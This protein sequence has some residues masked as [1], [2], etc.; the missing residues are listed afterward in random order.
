[1]FPNWLYYSDI[2][3]FIYRV[4]TELFSV[5]IYLYNMQATACVVDAYEDNNVFVNVSLL[6]VSNV[7]K[8]NKEQH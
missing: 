8:C 7:S 6:V 2:T 1:M 3:S 4:W 5:N